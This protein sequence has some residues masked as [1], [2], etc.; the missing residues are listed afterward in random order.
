MSLLTRLEMDQAEETQE[1]RRGAGPEDDGGA[2]AGFKGSL[3]KCLD[4]SISI[5]NVGE[6]GLLFSPNKM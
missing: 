4:Y 1:G 3:R 6:R 5:K 2:A